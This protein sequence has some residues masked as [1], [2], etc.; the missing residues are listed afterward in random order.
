MPTC[1]TLPPAECKRGRAFFRLATCNLQGLT[2]QLRFSLQSASAEPT[3]HLRA[4]ASQTTTY[5]VLLIHNA[6]DACE[7]GSGPVPSADAAHLPSK[8]NYKHCSSR[9]AALRSARCPHHS[10]TIYTHIHVQASMHLADSAMQE[11]H[12][13]TAHSALSRHAMPH[14]TRARP[15]VCR[16][17]A[18]RCTITRM[19]VSRAPPPM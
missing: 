15:P 14:S 3:M 10:S 2:S 11:Q 1:A 12:Q 19:W 5:Y 8:P 6:H 7:C 16:S 17:R 9:D 13:R 18:P 4:D